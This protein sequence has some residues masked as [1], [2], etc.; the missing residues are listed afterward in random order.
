MKNIINQVLLIILIL[1]SIATGITKI[2][3]MPAEME[4]FQHAG[5]TTWMIIA[6]GIV[7]VLGG[8][9]HV[10][11]NYRK[12][13]AILMLITF[14]IATIVVFIKGMI[15][16][17]IASLLFIALAGYQWKINSSPVI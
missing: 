15:G 4:L 2:I 6:F 14:I 9:L 1:L 8:I 3:Q 16:F 17:G 5:F 12:H 7:Q 10:F 13:G 11:K